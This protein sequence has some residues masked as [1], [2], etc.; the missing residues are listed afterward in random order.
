MRD[1]MPG[2]WLFKVVPIFI[3]VVFVVIVCA[4]IAIG[5]VGVKL[6]NAASSSHCTP[7]IITQ[8]KD[9]KTTTSL[10]CK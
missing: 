5:V 1:K 10:G 7:A 4:Y 9:G 3:G 6:F 8:T 2:D